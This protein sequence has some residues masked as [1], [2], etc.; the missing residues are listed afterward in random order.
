MKVAQT[1]TTT[2][3]TTTAAAAATATTTTTTTQQ[4]Q[5]QQ[6]IKNKSASRAAICSPEVA[7]PRIGAPLQHGP[8]QRHGGALPARG[9]PPHHQALEI[10]LILIMRKINS[11]DKRELGNEIAQNWMFL[12]IC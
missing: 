7:P 10:S 4:Q 11:I 5:Q 12:K 3:T 1:T 9:A 6:D 8:P 2:T